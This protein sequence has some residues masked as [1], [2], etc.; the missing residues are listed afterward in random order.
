MELRRLH[1]HESMPDRK[2]VASFKKA[3]RPMFN[4]AVRQVQHQ[5]D[6]ATPNLNGQA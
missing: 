5:A 6:W 3:T 1:L 2:L 4:F